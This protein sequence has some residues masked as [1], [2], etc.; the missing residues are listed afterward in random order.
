[1]MPLNFPAQKAA[2]KHRGVTG[3]SPASGKRAIDFP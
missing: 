1:M 3:G 2:A